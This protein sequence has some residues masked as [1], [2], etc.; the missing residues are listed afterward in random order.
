M[1]RN[2]GPLKIKVGHGLLTRVNIS[3]PQYYP[4]YTE[5]KVTRKIR[6]F[7]RVSRIVDKF[8]RRQQAAYVRANTCLKTLENGKIKCSLLILIIKRPCVELSETE[9][10]NVGSGLYASNLTYY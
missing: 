2:H 5:R 1:Y 9:Q 7:T 10:L 3:C 6:V 4:G 8:S